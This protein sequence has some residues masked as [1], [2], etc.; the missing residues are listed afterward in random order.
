MQL[1]DT[2][3][4]FLKQTKCRIVE[5]NVNGASTKNPAPK[6]WVILRKRGTKIVREREQEFVVKP[7]TQ[8]LPSQMSDHVLSKDDNK[9]YVK[10]R[11]MSMRLNPEQRNVGN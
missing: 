10:W 5:S 4:E 7:Y 8:T 3:T 6:T 1:I 2:I 11:R 9:R